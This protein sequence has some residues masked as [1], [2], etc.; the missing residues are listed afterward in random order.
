VAEHPSIM[1]GIF[2]RP[3]DE[4]VAFFR[5]KLGNL[6][7]TRRWDDMMRSAHDTGFMVAGAAKADLLADF[8]AAVDRVVAEGKGLEA[9]R[10]DFMAIAERR[11]WA[12]FTGDESPARRAWR[13][14]TIYTTN[15]RTSYNAGRNAQLREAEYPY[16]IY[17]HGDSRV[18]RPQHLAWDGLVLPADDPFWQAHK[19]QNGW[20]C[21]CYILGARSE[22]G[23][24]RLGGDPEKKKPANW[25]EID[26]KTGA[27]VG[28]DK[29]WDYAPGESVVD[30]V[31]KMAEK[32]RQW[33]YTLAKAFMQGVP[34][35]VRDQLARSYRSLPSVADDARRYA[36]RVIEQRTAAD[37][38]P[39]LTMG[40]LT[41]D[42][43]AAVGRIKSAEVAG[44]DYAFDADA[45]R[46][47][48]GGHGGLDSEAP[49]GQ[50][51]VTAAD[52]GRLPFLLNTAA[53]IMDVGT[54]YSTGQPV[55]EYR[56][57]VDGEKWR[58][59]FEIRRKRRM[60]VPI[61]LYITK[62]SGQP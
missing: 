22:R 27:P 58:A 43:A 15:A 9:F 6:V 8:A 40:L 23:A 10:R 39:Y 60:M 38:P 46:H 34:E 20:G 11:G 54:S 55:I 36:G 3:F 14:R 32:T 53:A 51:Q 61:S 37:I 30:E 41:A 5:S 12:G 56:W 57:D 1:T 18:P 45:V 29:G 33:E 2:K 49:R 17:R 62:E 24:R 19:P 50:R 7:P 21:T 35:S 13:T 59:V 25:D 52:Y 44:Y 4:Q 48:Q 47:I 16:L 28:I 26:P 31:R 42:D